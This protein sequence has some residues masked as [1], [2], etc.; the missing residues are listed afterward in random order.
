MRR[1]STIIRSGTVLLALAAVLPAC[2][3]G[4]GS[5]PLT[6]QQLS[7]GLLTMADV[8]YEWNETQRQTFDPRGNENPS[9]D[10]SM[11]C[12]DAASDA[13]SLQ[14]LA[15]DAGADVEMEAKGITGGARLLRQQAW[16]DDNAIDY[17]TAVKAAVEACDGKSWTDEGGATTTFD[18]LDDAGVG[19]ESVGFASTITP[20]PG[21]EKQK[22]E[23]RGRL[24]VV[25]Q[26]DIVMVLQAGDFAPEGST[27][28]LSESAWTGLVE[29]AAKRIEDL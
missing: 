28:V 22:Y 7:A 4:G 8:K 13:S 29:A 10:P 25:R 3:S 18:A 27:N 16:S 11:F 21:T 14:T 6:P 17:V 5:N 19:D 24:I 9:I 15:G 26:G 23:S 2:K 1:R 12:P 20:P